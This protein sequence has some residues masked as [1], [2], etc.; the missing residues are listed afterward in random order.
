MERPVNLA[1]TIAADQVG[2]SKIRLREA[3]LYQASQ[4]RRGDLILEL[5]WVDRLAA[6]N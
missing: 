1:V 6:A 3:G 2:R 4:A 5:I